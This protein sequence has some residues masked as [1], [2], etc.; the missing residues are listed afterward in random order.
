MS[1]ETI[2]NLNSLL[3]DGLKGT[4]KPGSKVK[5]A[6]SCF[7]MF[8]YEAL[9]DELEKV[10]S[11]E[12]IFTSPTFA[13]GEATDKI[14]KERRE[15]YIP[16]LERERSLYGTEFEIKLRNKLNQ[17]AIARECADWIK[18]KASF[19][20][21]ATKSL[22][23][24][25]A[26]IEDPSEEPTAYFPLQGFTA[27]DLGYQ[28]GEAL[29]NFVNKY[30]G[31]TMSRKFLSTFDQIWQDKEKLQD[32]TDQVVE[33]IS[34]VYLENSPERIYFVMLYNIFS[35]FLEDID[36]DVLPNERTGY[37]DSVVWKKLFNF[38]RDAAVGL[39]NK[40]ETYNGCILA[41][42]VGLGKTF[43][44]L[45]VIKYYELRNKSVLVLCPKKLAN[46]WQT[47]NSPL[48]TNILADDRLNYT[49]L[50]H[51]DLQRTSGESYG[52]PLNQINWAIL[53]SSSLM[54]R[55]T[56]EI[57]NQVRR[58]GSLDTNVL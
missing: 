6:A 15:F 11:V 45:A 1:I 31:E 21:N 29:S 12:F 49:V 51:T 36:E 9:R 4:L 50:N 58:S 47:Y 43:T 19:R 38:Q 25:M 20:S 55:T 5:I 57:I 54:N 37:E 44:A 52:I 7:S 35:E 23:Q 2:D 53:T 39:I 32:E 13:H 30:S 28:K 34:S 10:D 22:M 56:S 41:D 8:A 33:H 40:L 46:N 24:Q 14:S 16:R 26:C 42:S 18:R 3:G 48:K 27:V 17:R